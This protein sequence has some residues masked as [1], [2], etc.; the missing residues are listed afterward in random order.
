MRIFDGQ[1]FFVYGDGVSG[2]AAYRA[3]KKR[4]GKVR[5]Y[6]DMGGVFSPPSELDY[7]AAVISP[8]IKADHPVYEYCRARGIRAMG[9]AE[10]GFRLANRPIIGVTGTNGKTTT[11]MLI[12]KMTGGVACGNIG[13]PLTAACE[14][15]ASPLVC[16][17]SSFQLRDAK[18]VPQIAVITNIAKDHIDWHG[19]E[20]EYYRCKCNIA[21]N[22]QGGYLILGE[23]ITV[24]ALKSLTTDARIIRCADTPIDGAYVEDGYFKFFGERVCPVGYLRLQGEHNIKN[25]LCAMAAAKVF[26]AE[27]ADILRAMS[28]A[29]SAPHRTEYA[30]SACGKRWIDDSK[31]TNISATLAAVNATAGEICLIVGGLDKGLDF[32]ELFSALPS[33]VIEVVAMGDCAEKIKRGAE[34]CGF[35]RIVTVVGGLSAAVETASRSAADT[36]L[37]SPAC[38]SFDEFKNY[39]ERGERFGA[40]VSALKKRS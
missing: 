22:M 34:T 8:G 16:E 27:N 7:T 33:N 10:L 2:R 20:A 28:S 4:G 35:D 26:G 24:G 14:T 18:I 40:E 15:S 6:T 29:E 1:R 17:L 31:G 37:L 21:S 32:S 11:T 25:A 3:I 13:Y 9:E 19:S 38:A 5:I 23:D 36:V 39:G 30:G 12:A